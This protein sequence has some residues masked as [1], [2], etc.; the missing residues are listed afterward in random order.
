L[1]KTGDYFRSS[2]RQKHAKITPCTLIESTPPDSLVEDRMKACLLVFALSAS[3]FSIAC[4]GG[5]GAGSTPPPNTYTVGGTIS[6]LAGAGLVLQDN[7][8][9]NLSVTQNGNFTFSAAVASGSAFSVAVSTQ[10]SSPAQTCNVTNGSGTVNTNITTVEVT[11][12]TNPVTNVW[13]WIGGSNVVNQGTVYGS[14]GTPAEGNTPGA[15]DSSAAW[16]DTSG[17]FWLFSGEGIS[18]ANDLWRYSAG[19]WTWIG[20]SSLTNQPGSY[21]TIGVASP[22]NVPGTRSSGATWRDAAGN[23]WL[24]GGYGLDSNGTIGE[25]NDLWEY[26]SGEWTWMSGSDLVNPPGVYG[27]EGTGSATNLPGGRYYPVSWIDKAGNLWLFGGIGEDGSG[28][29]GPLNDLWEY[30]AGEWTW[31]NG[32]N[33]ANPVGVYG[34]K[35]KAAAANVPGAR[36]DAVGWSDSSGNLWLFGGGGNDSAG[37]LGFLNDLWEFSAGEWSWMGGSNLANQPATYGTEGTAAPGNTPA[38]RIQAAAWADA[39]GNFWL[40]GGYGL[41]SSLST[42][43]LNDLW[44]YSAGEWTWV[45]GSDVNGQTGIYGTQGAPAATNIPGGRQAPAVWIDSSGN[46][47]IFGGAGYDSNGDGGELNDLWEYQP[48]VASSANRHTLNRQT[49]LR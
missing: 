48:A 38:G 43:K 13:T 41:D 35:G 37:T 11:C 30:S 5:A 4:G 2:F 15:R 23:F 36:S 47:W 24:F 22:T 33:T 28:L 39:A 44:Q 27:T 9:N 1:D 14:E 32:S 21:G 42:G 8:G 26:S 45:S 46:F 10:P 12:T 25:L 18:N 19:E 31:V 6:G 20:G 17:N 7:G 40:F 29:K 16:S 34:T 49:P 3:V